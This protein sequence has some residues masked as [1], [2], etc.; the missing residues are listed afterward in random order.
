MFAG[1]MDLFVTAADIGEKIHVV[2]IDHPVLLSGLMSC[3]IVI[4]V[5]IIVIKAE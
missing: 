4:M 5:N 3:N 1:V 2:I